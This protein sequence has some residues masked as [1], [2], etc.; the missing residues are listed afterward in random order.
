MLLSDED[1]RAKIGRVCGEWCVCVCVCVCGVHL[2]Q[3][4]APGQGARFILLD[5]PCARRMVHSQGP[6]TGFR[7][8]RI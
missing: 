5:V 2:T 6:L 3:L 4:Y 8:Y 7:P 1:I